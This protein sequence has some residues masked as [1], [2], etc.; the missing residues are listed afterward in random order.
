MPRVSGDALPFAPAAERNR[1]PILAALREHLP[2][3]GEVLEIGAGTGQHAVYFA[4]E[5]PGL[6]WQP[7]DRA[8]NLPGLRAR[9]AAEGPA[10]CHPPVELN[11]AAEAWPVARAHVVYAANVAHIMSWER[12]LDL[13]AG[14]A[15]VLVPGGLLALYG[16]FHRDG[17]PTADSNAAFDRELRARDPQQGIRDDREVVAAAAAHGLRLDRDIDLPANNRLLLFRRDGGGGEV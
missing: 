13:L 1:G 5:C 7:S 11:V 15:R 3:S 16:P 4:T 9:V 14:A 17:R 12:V 2:A 10:N 8:G 6:T